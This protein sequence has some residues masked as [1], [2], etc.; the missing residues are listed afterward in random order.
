M[1]KQHRRH[2]PTKGQVSRRDLIR[3]G[4]AGAAG[5]AA[6]GPFGKAVIPTAHGMPLANHKRLVVINCYGGYDGLNLMPVV[7]GPAAQAYQDRRP[8]I[9]IDPLD[10]LALN[11]VTDYALHPNMTSLQTLFN[12]GEAATFQKVGYPTADLSHFVSQDIYS[13]GVRNSFG[14]LGIPA[15]G[16][17][18]RYA[19]LYAPTPLGACAIGVG[20]PL[21]FE[22]G[23]TDPLTLFN[24]SSFQFFG[25]GAHF[26]N[27]QHQLDTLETLLGGFSGNA[28]SDAAAVAEEQGHQLSDDIQDALANSASPQA[29]NYPTTTPGTFLKDI[30]NLINHGTETEIFTGLNGWDT[31]ASQTDANDPNLGTMADL[32]TRL[33]GALGVFTQDLKDMNVW[34][35]TLVLIVTEFGRRN[36]ENASIGTDHGHGNCFFATGGNVIGGYYGPQ[37]AEADILENFLDYEIDFRD[38]YKEAVT[39]HLGVNAAPIFPEPLVINTAL[40]YLPV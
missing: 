2:T 12:A 17:I 1:C 18:A 25:D 40:N 6:L 9:A 34:N 4:I 30:A 26:E 21:D 10:T 23:A 20:L 28:L 19:E 32:I 13:F 27:S 35:D 5:I 15:S 38:I 14:P 39:R 16:W 36:F 24:L 37:L 7:A 8:S 22:G 29:A 11:G 33:D 31:H 3:Y